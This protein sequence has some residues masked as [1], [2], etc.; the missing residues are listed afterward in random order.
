MA[1]RLE[2]VIATLP[3][4]RQQAI[5]RETER[6]IAEEL[7]LRELRKTLAHSQ[8]MIGKKLGVKQAEVSKIE[9]RA[10]MY[11]STLRDYV[12]AMGGEL[13]I[14]VRFPQHAPV[15]INQ[16]EDLGETAST[17]SRRATRRKAVAK[18]NS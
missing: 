15:R 5:Q 3:Q 9:R 18:E 17:R 6:L 4:E 14:I 8:E 10:D 16:F 11:V 2:D 1:K 13:D 7:S 12:E